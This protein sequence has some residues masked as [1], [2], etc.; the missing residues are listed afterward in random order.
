M[1]TS[2]A[3]SER[4]NKRR[5]LSRSSQKALSFIADEK[6]KGNITDAQAEVLRKYVVA[7]YI[8][9][10]LEINLEISLGAIVKKTHQLECKIDD[11]LDHMMR[12]GG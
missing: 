12:S 4:A 3:F 11:V 2:H 9:E 6:R 8:G 1:L 10:H 7:A 5:A